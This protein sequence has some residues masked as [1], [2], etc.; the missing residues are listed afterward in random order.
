[1][2]YDD[3]TNKKNGNQLVNYVKDIQNIE[4]QIN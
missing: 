3:G 4:F 2:R 1:M